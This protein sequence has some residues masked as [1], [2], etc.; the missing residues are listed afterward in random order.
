MNSRLLRR[1]KVTA[2]SHA[3]PVL[4]FPLA[5][6]VLESRATPS[7]A[8]DPA[9]GLLTVLGD[10]SG[11]SDDGLTV[12]VTGGFIEVTINNL[13]QS[14]DPVSPSFDPALAGA[15]PTTILSI[16]IQGLEGNDTITLG[17]GFLAATSLI[18]LNGGAG[19]DT[20]LGGNTN[21]LLDGGEGSDWLDFSGALVGV[22]VDLAKNKAKGAGKDLLASIENA[23]GSPFGDKLTG[24][25]SSNVLIGGNGNDKLNGGDGDDSFDGGAGDDKINGGN[26][27]DSLLA[28]LGN[29]SLKTIELG[30]PPPP[31]ILFTSNG[32]LTIQGDP[33]LPTDDNL[34]LTIVTVPC[35]TPGQCPALDSILVIINGIEH[36][37][38]STYTAFDP[39]LTGATKTSIKSILIHGNDGDDSITLGD[40][41]NTAAGRI[42]LRGGGGNDTVLG[43]STGDTILG[44][45]GDDSLVGNDGNDSLKGGDD[46]DTVLG[47]AG[48][49]ILESGCAV[50]GLPPNDGDDSFDGAAGS[51][52]LVG[53]LGFLDL[54]VSVEFN[55]P[56]SSF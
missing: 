15:T 28:N 50:G 35:Q 36:S 42:T 6:D 7:V 20:L 47:G 21:D 32:A 33:N 34:S 9:T 19:N 41:F 13:T 12:N 54:L 48:N 29:D 4:R 14:S 26:G 56:C 24:G 40:G 49:D 30:L 22:K 55:S 3:A 38:D 37:S 44:G 5:F 17:D 46:D 1:R 43:G 51:D 45:S 27:T 10:E 25:I 53:N 39:F 52:T 16:L 18:T 31:P 2:K 23:I 11:A 8:F